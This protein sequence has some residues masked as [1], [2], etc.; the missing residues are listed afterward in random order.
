M[1]HLCK[2]NII[3]NGFKFVTTNKTYKENE[4][5]P[6]PQNNDYLFNDKTGDKYTF[7]DLRKDKMIATYAG[8]TC[9]WVYSCDFETKLKNDLFEPIVVADKVGDYDVVSLEN[10]FSS[11]T[12]INVEKIC[13]TMAKAH[14]EEE[15]SKLMIPAHCIDVIKSNPTY[16]AKLKNSILHF[17]SDVIECIRET[18]KDMH[19]PDTVVNMDNA[20]KQTHISILPKLSKNTISINYICSDSDI[21]I[22][23]DLPQKVIY[24]KRAFYNCKELLA[25]IMDNH[26]QESRNS[27]IVE[28][29]WNCSNL[30]YFS[31][32]GDKLTENHFVQCPKLMYRPTY[33]AE[34]TTTPY[35]KR[36]LYEDMTE[37]MNNEKV[38]ELDME[39]GSIII[40]N[41][42]Y[43]A[44]K[45]KIFEDV[46]KYINTNISAIN[47]L[48]DFYN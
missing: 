13:K 32:F 42:R 35:P 27:D 1:L 9:G 44:E 31:D 18:I 26:F 43:I 48:K 7:N 11:F 6:T 37:F 3:D 12:K 33:F 14:M 24:A 38:K 10:A 17:T 23:Y 45:E 28:I 4:K 22:V 8:Y 16:I 25:I 30:L 15:L 19:I 5:M 46:E 47:S 34:N 20:F 39:I 21:K 36:I 29:F 40:N 41:A 2:N